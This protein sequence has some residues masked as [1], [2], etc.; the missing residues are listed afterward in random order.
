MLLN[1]E[2]P[3]FSEHLIYHVER[4]YKEIQ[5]EE[6]ANDQQIEQIATNWMK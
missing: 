6:D 2:W 4:L 1:M 5:I 3:L